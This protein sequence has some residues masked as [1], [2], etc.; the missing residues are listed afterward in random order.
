MFLNQDE[1]IQSFSHNTIG[2][3]DFIQHG[4][5][6]KKDHQKSLHEKLRADIKHILPPIPPYDHGK[7]ANKIQHNFKEDNS[8]YNLHPEKGSYR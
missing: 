7:D 4:K 1:G 8:K 3:G 6:V 5:G 2:N